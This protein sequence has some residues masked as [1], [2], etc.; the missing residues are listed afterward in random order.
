MTPMKAFCRGLALLA[1]FVLMPVA[2]AHE[3][4]DNRATLVMRDRTHLSLTMYL[5]YTEAVHKA[6]APETS[7]WEFLTAVAALSPPDLEKQMRRAHEALQAGTRVYLDGM[8]PSAFSNWAWPQPVTAQRL[9]QQRLMEAT[10]GGGHRHHEEPIEVHADVISTSGV[11]GVNV[12]FSKA[13]GK[14]LLVWYRPRQAW[15]GVGKR[16]ASINFD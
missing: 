2:S 16:S 8:P 15:V 3:L 14:V 13:L 4:M 1:T 11:R 6:L 9:F 10:V 5:R 12:E 7:Y